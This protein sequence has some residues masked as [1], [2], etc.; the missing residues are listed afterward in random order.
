VCLVLVYPTGTEE[1]RVPPV[2]DEVGMISLVLDHQWVERPE[3]LVSLV[4]FLC[5]GRGRRKQK[6]KKKIGLK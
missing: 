6:R 3:W 2:A 4:F 1:R 5:C